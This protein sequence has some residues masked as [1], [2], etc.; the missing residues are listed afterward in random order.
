MD[1][2]VNYNKETKA[3]NEFKSRRNNLS[4]QKKNITNT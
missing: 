2:K 1:E 3:T 4:R